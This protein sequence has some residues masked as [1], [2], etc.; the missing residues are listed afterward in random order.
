[1]RTAAWPFLAAATCTSFSASSSALTESFT[2]SGSFAAGTVAAWMA[3][4][5]WAR[6][7]PSAAMPSDW[8]KVA[9]CDAAASSSFFFSSA[10]FSPSVAAAIF[11]ASTTGA[12]MRRNF[13]AMALASGS[14][15][16]SRSSA[17]ALTSSSTAAPIACLP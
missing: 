1:M 3:S 2:S 17:I 14:A 7:L 16:L 6:V 8:A 5:S 10:F 12:A 9:I 11:E 13:M 4:S 15:C